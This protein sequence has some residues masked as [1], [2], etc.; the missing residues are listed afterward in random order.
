MS[1]RIN[2]YARSLSRIIALAFSRSVPIFD[3]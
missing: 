3:P 2:G 1:T